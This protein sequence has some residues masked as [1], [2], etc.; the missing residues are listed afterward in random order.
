[1]LS[2]LDQPLETVVRYYN[3]MLDDGSERSTVAAQHMKVGHMQGIQEEILGNLET[4]WDKTNERTF[5]VMDDDVADRDSVSAP[6][7]EKMSLSTRN[8]A[9]PLFL[10]LDTLSLSARYSPA[11]EQKPVN[12]VF[13]GHARK[14]LS[15][16]ELLLEI[17]SLEREQMMMDHSTKKSEEKVEATKEFREQDTIPESILVQDAQLQEAMDRLKSKQQ[18][19]SLLDSLWSSWTESKENSSSPPMPNREGV[20]EMR[21]IMIEF[22]Y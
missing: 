5:N 13:D 11:S 1:M 21:R 18:G 17:D 2:Y 22:S 8:D 12:F 3:D 7:D 20:G 15:D 4:I 16:D 14:N 19:F 6:D 10:P 9:Q